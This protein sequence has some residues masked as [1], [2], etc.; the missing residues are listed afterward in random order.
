MVLGN[1]FLETFYIEFDKDNM[2][3][4]IKSNGGVVIDH[5]NELSHKDIVIIVVIC[6]A[7]AVAVI[8]IVILVY[9]YFKPKN[10]NTYTNRE[11]STKL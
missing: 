1:I 7:G 6:V 10:A 8:I 11:Y 3:I 4:G 9:C 2:R 5:S